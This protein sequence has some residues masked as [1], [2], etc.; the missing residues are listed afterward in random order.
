MRHFLAVMMIAALAVYLAACLGLFAA[1]RSFI[2]YPPPRAQLAAPRVWTFEAPGAVLTV[3]ERPAAGNRAVL[4]LGGNAEDVSASLPLLEH[5]FPAHAIY[6]LHYRGYTGSSGTPTEEA[7]VADALALLDRVAARH[8]EIVV[9][10]RSLG[11]GVAVQVA[12]RRPV[13][14]LVLVTPFDSL[15]ELA[16]QQFPLFP[17]RWLLKDKYES[18]RYAPQVRA[19][20][21]IVA[22]ERDEIVPASSTR[23]LLSRFAPGIAT[24]ETIAGAGH[25]T[26]SDSP[27]YLEALRRAQ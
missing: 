17:V 20:T 2:Y 24:M 7:L 15:Q 6:L 5:A 13:H 11:T 19:P 4:Y 25:D 18:W 10:G 22:A 9:V 23:K 3:S 26:V 21:L 1:Q 14:R 8:G 16:A 12:G 27:A